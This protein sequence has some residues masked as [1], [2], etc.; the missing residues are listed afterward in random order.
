MRK[1]FVTG[2]G[3]DVGKTIVAAILTE[4]LQADYWKP[5]Q[6]GSLEL[7]DTDRVKRLV[8]SSSTVFHEEG[9]R[10]AMPA[11]PHQAAKAEDKKIQLGKLT[12]PETENTLIIEGAGG[13]LVP[14]NY[15]GDTM[16]EI[17]K[18]CDAEVII[19]ASSY[20]GSI[21]HTLLT[22]EYLKTQDV[23]ILGVIFNGESNPES[24]QVILNKSKLTCLGRI[25]QEFEISKDIVKK[26]AHDYVFI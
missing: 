24:E 6:C 1:I 10:L 14:Y 2:I 20:L 26:Y 21:N 18:H 15:R 13:V 11:S 25:A 4:A 8:S 3:T 16:V 7:T 5:L 12:P 19:V 9:Y 22:L 17:I 23:N